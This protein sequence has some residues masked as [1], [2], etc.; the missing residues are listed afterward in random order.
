MAN[1]DAYHITRMGCG[2]PMNQAYRVAGKVFPNPADEKRIGNHRVT[3]FKFT[4]PAMQW[5]G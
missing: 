3:Y 5:G 1:P 2:L 4:K